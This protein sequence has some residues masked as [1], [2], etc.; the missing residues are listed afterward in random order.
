MKRFK[1]YLKWIEKNKWILFVGLI[2]L[3]QLFFAVYNLSIKIP[4]SYDQVDNAWAAKNIIVNHELPLVGM[5]AKANSNVYIGPLYYYFIAFFYWIFNLSPLASQA[6]SAV[7]NIFIFGVIFYVFKKLFSIKFAVIALL[8]NTFSFNILILSSIQWPVQLLPAV[9]LIIFYFLYKS[10]LGDI[11]KLIPLAIFTGIAFNL[12]F[13]A[14]FFPIIIL[15]TLPFFPRNK[16]TL[17]YILYS[18]PLFLIWIIPNAVY[19]IVNKAANSQATSYFSTYFHGFH[20]TRMIQIIGD[21]FIQFDPYLTLDWLKPFKL[22][23]FPL[24]F[25]IYGFRSLT[26]ERKIFL[27]LFFLWFMVPWL[28]FT[29]YA[30]EISDYY[31]IINRF[32]VLIIVTYFVYLVWELKFIVFKIAVVI[33]FVIYCYSNTLN[34]LPHKDPGNLSEREKKVKIEVD[35]NRRIEFQQ[36]APESYLYWYHMQKKGVD[37]YAPKAK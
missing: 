20:L 36:G 10:L 9:S 28:I 25:V 4:F 17:K 30:G 26:K 19:M 7:S 23:I 35:A 34:F 12:H 29:T 24:F 6:I 3:F 13:T 8:I 1:K 21:A 37:V 14:I 11:K 33:F 2:F 5:V 22:L 32:L 15:L 18:L 16:E 31:F 27:Y